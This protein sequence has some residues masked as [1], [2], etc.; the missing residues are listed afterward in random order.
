MTWKDR[1]PPP[2]R[3]TFFKEYATA[4]EDRPVAVDCALGTNPVGSPEGVMK[5]LGQNLEGAA[6]ISSYPSGDGIFRKTL[7]AA[8]G[9]AFAPEEV[10][11]G[12]GSI[13]L[14]ISL[15]RTFCG[16]GTTV[17]GLRPQFPDGPLHFRLAG[18]SYTSVQLKSPDFTISLDRLASELTGEESLVY[19]DR[20]HNPTGQ[21]VP[22]EDV[23]ALADACSQKGTLLVVD[24]AYGDFLPQKE[25][26]IMLA[27]TNIITLRSFAKGWGLA[28]LRAGYAVVRNPEARQF[29]AKV[30]PPFSVNTIAAELAMVALEDNPF[31]VRARETVTQIKGTVLELVEATFGVRASNTHPAVPILLLTH[32]DPAV[33]L[34]EVLMT[35]GIRTESGTCFEGLDGSSVRLRVPAPEDL[36]LFARLWNRALQ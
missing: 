3:D 18:A 22:L 5:R 20:P 10:V 12:T 27:K 32:S 29:I 31:L 1:M 16:P 36:Q 35:Q 9:G 24:E 7:S 13:G 33:D 34:Y 2:V 15:A 14:L 17:A 23:G 6:R 4:G 21:A 30:A 19:I 26:S 28:G 8:W 25:S 11:L